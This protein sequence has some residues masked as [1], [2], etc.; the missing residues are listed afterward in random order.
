MSTEITDLLAADAA[1]VRE[2]RE[3]AFLNNHF[4]LC[5]LAERRGRALEEALAEL[6]KQR[7]RAERYYAE[8][9]I[10]P[11]SDVMVHCADALAKVRA[12]LEGKP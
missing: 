3:N 10:L 6:E 5:D 11:T 9:W 2:A 1:K 8:S 7:E 12:I 4:D